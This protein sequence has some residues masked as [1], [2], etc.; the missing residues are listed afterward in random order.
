MAVLYFL[1]LLSFGTSE[2]LGLERARNGLNG[3]NWLEIAG[4]YWKWLEWLELAGNGWKLQEGWNWL[5]MARNG[6][7]WLNIC[8][9][10]T[11]L[12]I[13]LLICKNFV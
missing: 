9:Y 4:Q 8:L 1:V 10:M 11:G 2:D 3:W 13:N 7:K 6:F 5:E 12:S